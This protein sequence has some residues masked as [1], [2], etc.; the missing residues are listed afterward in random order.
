M[1][2][3]V[4][5]K[6]RLL[7]RVRR[8]RGQVEALE[9]A[10]DADQGCAEVLHQIAAIRG[11]VGGLMAEVLEGHIRSHIAD[12]AITSDAERQQ[13]ADELVAV[14]RTYIK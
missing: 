14:L 1:S 5:E 13:G 9:R 2:H 11:A 8:I 3:T 12:P 10:L 6:S 4:Q 7:A